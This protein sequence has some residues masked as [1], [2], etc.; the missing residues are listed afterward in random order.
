MKKTSSVQLAPDYNDDTFD[1]TLS[2]CMDYL[3]T[4]GYELGRDCRIAY[5]LVD[6]DGIVFEE[7]GYCTELGWRL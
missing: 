4:Y 3:R 6:D 1:G 5:I 2:D 7:L